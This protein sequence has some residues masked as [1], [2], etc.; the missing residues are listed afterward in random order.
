MH[1][2]HSTPRKHLPLLSCSSCPLD[3]Y[4]EFIWLPLVTPVPVLGRDGRWLLAAGICVWVK[5]GQCRAQSCHWGGPHVWYSQRLHWPSLTVWEG[6]SCPYL[7][8]NPWNNS[9]KYTACAHDLK[10]CVQLMSFP[11]NKKEIAF[12]VY[13]VIQLLAMEILS[14]HSLRWLHLVL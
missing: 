3:S 4:S 11:V 5:G 12:L 2:V 9:K 13:F 1:S 10:G 8:L 6:L 14:L 7:G